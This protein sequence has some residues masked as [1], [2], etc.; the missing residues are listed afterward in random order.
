M[1][2]MTADRTTMPIYSQPKPEMAG[3]VAASKA[4]AP[5]GGCTVPVKVMTAD[6][7]PTASAPA[8]QRR[9]SKSALSSKSLV[10]H[11]PMTAA[12][13]CPQIWFR[14]CEKGDSIALNSR[15]AAAPY[16]SISKVSEALHF[17]GRALRWID[18]Q[19]CQ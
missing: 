6:D 12:R 16:G 2:V 15:M 5:A 9:F 17:E 19:S 3:S 11:T 7:R 1:W 8:S 4:V 14:G 10:M 18:I 13:N